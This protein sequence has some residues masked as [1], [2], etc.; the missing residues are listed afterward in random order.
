[1]GNENNDQQTDVRNDYFGLHDGGGT[2]VENISRQKLN[3]GTPLYLWINNS[4]F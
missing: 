3:S 4:L 2:T 1:M